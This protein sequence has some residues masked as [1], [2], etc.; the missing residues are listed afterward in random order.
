MDF[1]G[2]TGSYYTSSA[3]TV[4]TS[5]YGVRIDKKGEYIK[6]SH[7]AVPLSSMISCQ[8]D[9]EWNESTCKRQKLRDTR[10]AIVLCIALHSRFIRVVNEVIGTPARISVRWIIVLPC[11][12]R[13]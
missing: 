13:L 11:R 5:I 7:L 8:F 3:A 6:L 12:T 10:A 2:I 1:I 4:S 9:E